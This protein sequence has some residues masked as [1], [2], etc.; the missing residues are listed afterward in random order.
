MIQIQPSLFLV[1]LDTTCV[2]IYDWLGSLDIVLNS[3]I[4]NY[5][6]PG[7]ISKILRRKDNCLILLR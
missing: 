4:E 2:F 1:I 6:R 7:E 5:I 3:G